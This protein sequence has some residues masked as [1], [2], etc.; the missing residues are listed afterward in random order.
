VRL[1]VH[2]ALGRQ[3]RVLVDRRL[4]A[5]RHEV[6][7]DARDLASGTY[8]VRMEAAAFVTT[9]SVVLIE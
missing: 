4:P 5:G 7:F 3:R 1:T 2:D 9:R 6:E 8:F